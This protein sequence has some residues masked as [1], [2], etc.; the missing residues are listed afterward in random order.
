MVLNNFDFKF[1]GTPDD[2]GMKTG[3]TIHTMNGL[4]MYVTKRS[5]DEPPEKLS[6]WW[7]K[8]HLQRGLNANGRPYS[9]EEE[10]AWDTST[11]TTTNGLPKEIGEVPKGA[12]GKG[13]CPV[14]H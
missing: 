1:K 4:N 7:E 11:R 10:A 13:G 12:A 5:T 6:G 8:Q 14:D 3:A 9:N 2:V